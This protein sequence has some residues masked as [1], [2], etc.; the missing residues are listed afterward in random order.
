MFNLFL[1]KKD[2]RLPDNYQI[3]VYYLDG[4]SD[5]IEAASHCFVGPQNSVLEIATKD[6]TWENIYVS[7]IKKITYDKRFSKMIAIKEERERKKKE[8]EEKMEFER[9][10][11]EELK[12]VV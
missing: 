8:L 6:D 3:T 9:K 4:T 5:T 2:Q 12:K 11:Q 10:K 1:K 7:C